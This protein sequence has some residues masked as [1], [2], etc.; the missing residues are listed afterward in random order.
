MFDLV[1]SF[2]SHT[3]TLNFFDISV[4][5]G[6]SS[7]G[8]KLTNFQI[9][10]VFLL[11]LLLLN[12]LSSLKSLGCFIHAVRIS[13]FTKRPTGC[14]IFFPCQHGNPEHVLTLSLK[15]FN[16]EAFSPKHSCNSDRVKMALTYHS[17]SLAV[18]NILYCHLILLQSK[19]ET[20]ELFMQ[21][22]LVA[23]KQVKNLENLLF[24]TR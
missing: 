21:P 14:F 3:S 1:I 11:S 23:Y 6:P 5:I 13:I 2:T 20:Y 24:K 10:P 12:K 8:Y 4:T 16:Q 7:F 18:K 15:H 19:S 9:L 22:P 17:H